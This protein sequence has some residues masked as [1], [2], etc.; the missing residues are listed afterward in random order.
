MHTEQHLSRLAHSLGADYFGIADLSPA[1]DFIHLQGGERVARYPRAIAIGIR[2][3]DSL[4][5]LLPDKD[6]EG[7]ML[8][9]H[10]SYDVVNLMLDQIGV[11]IANEPSSERVIVPSLFRRPDELTMKTSAV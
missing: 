6:S 7:A 3:Q 10:N 11:R 8:Y 5:D 9:R 4:V 1:R 2:L